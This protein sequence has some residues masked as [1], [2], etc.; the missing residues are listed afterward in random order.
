LERLSRIDMILEMLKNEPNDVF[1][2][3]TLG[4]EHLAELNVSDAELQFKIAL[5]L[6]PNY[7]AA[8]YQLGKLYESILKNQEALHYFKLGLEKAKLQKNNKA[9]N[10][11]GEAIFMLED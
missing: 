2:N 4:L 10:E 8:Y 9:I 1:L 3:Y 7:I 11:F 5:R 6:N